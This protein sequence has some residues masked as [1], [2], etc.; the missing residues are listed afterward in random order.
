MDC[1]AGVPRIRLQNVPVVCEE[2]GR[3]IV[4]RTGDEAKEEHRRL[5]RKELQAC[6]T[7]SRMSYETYHF[8]NKDRA[9]ELQVRE[10]ARGQ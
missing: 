8:W 4:R 1:T 2:I 6:W 9:S 7:A 5:M 3:N 10:G